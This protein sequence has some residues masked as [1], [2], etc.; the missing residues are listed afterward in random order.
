MNY[1]LFCL[2]LL[3]FV[4]SLA[5]IAFTSFSARG[6]GFITSFTTQGL[7]RLCVRFCRRVKSNS[8]LRFAGLLIVC[9]TLLQWILLIWASAL[10][11]SV[12]D[13]SSIINAQTK[14]PATLLEKVYVTGYSLSTMGNGDYAGGSKLWKIFITLLSFTGIIVVTVS[15]TYLVQV[16]QGVTSK[17][18]LSSGIS[19]LGATPEKLLL[20][21]WNGKDFSS[22]NMP[23]LLLAGQI[24]SIA[25]KHLSYPVLHYYYS[26]NR[27]KS[28]P[29]NLAVLD[30][31]M[32]ILY[33]LINQEHCTSHLAVHSARMSVSSFLETLKSNFI[34]K[35]A[36][37]PPVPSL[38]LLAANN[39]P[40]NSKQIQWAYKENKNRRMLLLGLLQ[41]D[42][43][44]WQ[45]VYDD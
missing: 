39:V 7:W 5:D 42:G 25:E 17:R 16:L 8:F 14:M 40:V 10:I 28:L 11:M 31:A 6:A 45:D 37:E 15:L 23:L 9:A 29:V 41:D 1:F 3:L 2:G 12:S 20:H 24:T 18:A 22:V 38:A 33:T 44:E 21:A 19:S 32:T 30:E 34:S 36:M 27:S 4:N 26:E 35:A 13:R 43:R